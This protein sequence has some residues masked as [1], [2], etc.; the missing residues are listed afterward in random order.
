MELSQSS[1]SRHEIS[2]PEVVDRTKSLP[3]RQI[4]LLLE[5]KYSR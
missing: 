2:D 1:Q 3:P 5:K 4:S